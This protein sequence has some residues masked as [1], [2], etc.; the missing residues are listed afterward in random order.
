[1]P[2]PSFRPDLVTREA[3]VLMPSDACPPERAAPQWH[4]RSVAVPGARVLIGLHGKQRPA[5]LWA[6]VVAMQGERAW[7]VI[8]SDAPGQAL[9]PGESLQIDPGA[10]AHIV[11]RT[12]ADMQAVEDWRRTSEALA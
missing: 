2:A 6:G 12:P 7:L 11:L 10:H 3:A 5:W 9:R 4:D 8:L 1:M